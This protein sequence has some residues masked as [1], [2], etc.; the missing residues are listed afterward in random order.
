MIPMKKVL[1]QS[2]KSSDVVS[3]TEEMFESLN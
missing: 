3:K 1:L 2:Y